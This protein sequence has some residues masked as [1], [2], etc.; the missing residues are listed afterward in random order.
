MTVGAA[1]LWMLAFCAA[2]WLGVANAIGALT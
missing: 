2:F 1:W